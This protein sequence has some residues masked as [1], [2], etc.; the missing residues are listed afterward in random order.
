AAASSGKGGLWCVR[1]GRKA[2][3][4]SK[5]AQSLRADLDRVAAAEPAP[6]FAVLAR[7]FG[8]SQFEQD[9]LLL[10]AAM[11]IDTGVP[12]LVAAAQG[13]A[14]KRYPSFAL[15]MSLFES[16]SW[17]ALSSE[18][19]LRA[20]RLLEVHQSGAVS[21]LAAPLRID[22]RIA[23]YIKGLNDLDE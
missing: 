19:P 9:M 21:L 22:E 18:R 3:A 13:D 23:A 1:S 7:R 4:A 15:G 16:S 8:L 12:A 20:Q 17:D 14:G 11:E 10:A 2:S 6:A 5:S